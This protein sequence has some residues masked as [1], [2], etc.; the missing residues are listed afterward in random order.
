MKTFAEVFKKYRLRAEFETFASFGNALAEKGYFY[1]ESIFSH[2]QKGTRIPSNRQLVI[3][4]L[5]IFV[6][7]DAVRTIEEANDFL[8]SAGLGYLTEKEKEGVSFT[9]LIYTHFQVPNEIAYFTGRQSIIDNIVTNKAL[10]GNVILIHGPAG[11]GKTAL[12]IKLAH[13]LRNRYTDGVLWYKVEEDN[14]QDIL[15]SIASIFGEN[16]REIRSIQ[17]RATVVRSILAG[18]K[19]LIIF[20]SGELCDDIYLLIPNSR[21]CTTII[22]SQKNHFQIPIPFINI[23][24]K[25]FANKEVLALFKNVL[26]DKYLS[27]SPK[28]ILESANRLGNLPLAVH[29]FARQIQ[30]SKI[31]IKQIGKVIDEEEILLENLQYEDRNLYKAIDLSYRKIDTRMKSVLVSASIFKGKDFSIDAIGYINGFS[32]SSTRKILQNLVE[33]SL[34]EP[35]VKNRFRIHPGVREFVRDKLD[36]P[37]SSFLTRIA[38][39]FFLLYTISWIFLQLFVTKG[40]SMYLLFSATYGIIALYGGTIGMHTSL[41]WG[42]LKTL[43]GRSIFMFS[44]G[45]FLQEFGQLAYSYYAN[46]Q[47]IKVPYPSIGDI[48]YFGTIPFYIYGVSLLAESSGIKIS[49]QSFRKKIIALIVTVVMVSSA[50]LLFLQDYMFDF[51]NPIKIFL[52]FG[53]PLGDAIYISIAIIIFIFSRTILD[54]IMRSRALLLLVA[55]LMQFLADYIFVYYASNFYPGSH[56]DFLYLTA[57]FFMTIAILN[58]KSLQVKII[59]A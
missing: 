42:G 31:S 12:A 7:R 37:R 52:D 27:T 55:L 17:T 23:P 59:D 56:I 16:L 53:Y 49:I 4:I 57:Y 21:F 6:E 9:R 32:L 3:K 11:V 39:S 18:K 22:T 20:D 5:E 34:I 58:F 44:I 35:S 30:H 38:I 45:L 1:D 28:M 26:K 19:V 25:M 40:N 51:K 41:K 14:I 54:G 43:L 10:F 2:W 48:G 13:L 36:N 24:L 8:S 46:F 29:M 47:N 33:L 50:Y 15:F